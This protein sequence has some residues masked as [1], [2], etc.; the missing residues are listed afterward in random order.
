[1]AIRITARPF[2]ARL[3]VVQLFTASL[4]I[5]HLVKAK[6][7]VARPIEARLRLV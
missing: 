7:I 1:M 5:V 6:H 3:N 2:Q 4:R